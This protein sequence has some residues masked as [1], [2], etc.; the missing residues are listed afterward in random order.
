MSSI[1][2]L[3]QK[4]RFNLR[5]FIL[6]CLC[7]FPNG[8]LVDDHLSIFLFAVNP[9]SLVPGWRRRASSRFVLLNQSGKELLRTV[10]NNIYMIT[11]LNI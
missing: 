2:E 8:K 11:S 4:K 1:L 10:G 5:V 6:R 9:E 7:V 3:I